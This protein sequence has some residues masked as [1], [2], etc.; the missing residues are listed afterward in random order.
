[1]LTD[2][3]NLQPPDFSPRLIDYPELPQLVRVTAAALPG[4]TPPVYPCLV[5][6]F[7]PG[8]ATPGTRDREQ[9]YVFEPNSFPLGSA[10]YDCRLVASYL[11]LPLY[12]TSCC[13]GSTFAS[14]PSSS[15]GSAAATSPTSA[16]PKSS[17]SATSAAPAGIQRLSLGTAQGTLTTG[18]TLPSVTV[19]PGGLLIVVGTILG[20]SGGE[21]IL[22]RFGGTGMNKDVSQ[23]LTSPQAD[24][25]LVCF[26]VAKSGTGDIQ[27]SLTGGVLA[28]SMT[29]E[30][31]Q[32]TGLAANVFD[33]SASNEGL[34]SVPDTG[35]TGTTTAASEYAQAAFI[36]VNDVIGF[37]WANGFTSG[38]QDVSETVGG[39]AVKVTEGYLILLAK[40]TVDA[41]LS[42]IDPTAWAGLV[43]TYK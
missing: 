9:A 12:A 8:L 25:N 18:L 34:S 35:A 33:Q 36:L 26:S 19:A 27:L 29:I 1:M 31:V 22:C 15:R 14:S 5:Q 32:V 13:V 10:I 21:T 28:A 38:G 6:Q 20:V 11:G 40:G 23:V 17:A 16:A 43:A 2:S 37:T 7:N 4:T 30:A 42:G 3:T 41:S 39:V 24:G